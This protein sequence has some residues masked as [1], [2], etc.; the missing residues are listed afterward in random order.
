MSVPSCDGQAERRWLLSG[1]SDRGSASVLASQ[2]KNSVQNFAKQQTH[3]MMQIQQGSMRYIQSTHYRH[4]ISSPRMDQVTLALLPIPLPHV[5]ADRDTHPPSSFRAPSRYS[6]P[7]QT[8]ALQ[9]R[10]PETRTA[11]QMSDKSAIIT[12]LRGD[13]R[14]SSPRCHNAKSRHSPWRC[15]S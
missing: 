14:T 1:S 15:N 9:E 12:L 5:P 3:A 11:H 4:L 8:V 7:D 13:D 6:V 2:T 10:G